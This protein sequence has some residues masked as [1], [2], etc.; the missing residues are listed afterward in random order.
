MCS[1][2][3]LYHLL[4]SLKAGYNLTKRSRDREVSKMEVEV[5]SGW[6]DK[7]EG[8]EEECGAQGHSKELGSL[9]G[10]TL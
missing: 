4:L 8:L 2:V 10:R 5:E 3:P 7:E 9:T 6:P 1:L